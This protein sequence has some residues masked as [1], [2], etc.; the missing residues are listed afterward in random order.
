VLSETALRELDAYRDEVPQLRKDLAAANER[1]EQA[2]RDAQERDLENLPNRNPASRGGYEFYINE[3]WQAL[4]R[5]ALDEAC[6]GVASLSKRRFDPDDN[7]VRV[8]RI[9]DDDALLH[10]AAARDQ[11]ESDNAR[12]REALEKIASM[13]PG[14]SMIDLR[15]P[16]G[17]KN[18]VSFAYQRIARAAL[19][20][21]PDAKQKGGEA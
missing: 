19:A 21:A 12:L 10:D 14:C 20:D 13:P 2:E 16:T 3:E 6:D 9:K 1:A 4:A 11:L 17:S 15:E 18:A 5:A 8:R 7:R